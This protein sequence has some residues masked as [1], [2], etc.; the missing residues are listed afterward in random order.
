MKKGQLKEKLYSGQSALGTWVFMPCVPVVEIIGLSNFDFIVIDMEH[1]PISFETAIELIIAAENYN[2]TPI[3]RVSSLHSSPILRALDSGAHGVQVPHIEK[4]EDAKKVIKFTKYHPVGLRGMAPNSRGG[5]YTY[6]DSD[7]RSKSE[8]EEIL[9]ILNVEG[10]EGVNNLPS[11]L[12]LEDIDIIFIGPYDL[13]QSA[14]YP[15]QIEHPKVT[16]LIEEST[17][18]IKDAGKI[19]GCF[20]GNEIQSKHLIDLGVQ[21]ITYSADGPIV[22]DAFENINHLFRDI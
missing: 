9:T 20:A 6:H 3:I 18:A 15:G 19:P 11:I 21:Y 16:R 2:L 10:I 4:F 14:G 1:S 17:K 22:R 13:S 8:N 5:K 12:E 7:K